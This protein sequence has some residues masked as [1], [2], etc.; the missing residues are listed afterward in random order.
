MQWPQKFPPQSLA[1]KR[2]AIINLPQLNRISI[3]P[4][5]IGTCQ[6]HMAADWLLTL[7]SLS[8]S[9]ARNRTVEI[10]AKRKLFP[11]D[12]ENPFP[13]CQWG[14]AREAFVQGE[15]GDKVQNCQI[16]RTCVD[17]AGILK[18]CRLRNSFSFALLF[19][20]ETEEDFSRRN[21]KNFWPSL[22][23]P[24]LTFL[25]LFAFHFKHTTDPRVFLPYVAGT[26]RRPWM[27][28]PFPILMC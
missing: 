20:C 4:W 10:D 18:R 11:S 12:I 8:I 5:Q 14:H 17:R 6:M 13:V 22:S 7:I 9:T 27:H 26:F 28:S 2:G 23:F 25:L 19:C 24:Y 3:W 1:E 15:E 21:R 16:T